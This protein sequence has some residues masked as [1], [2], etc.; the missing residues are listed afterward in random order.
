MATHVGQFHGAETAVDPFDGL[1]GLFKWILD[2]VQLVSAVFVSA[3]MLGAVLYY[4]WNPLAGA[5]SLGPIDGYWNC[6]L[7]VL[8]AFGVIMLVSDAL[9]GRLYNPWRVFKGSMHGR[10]M[11]KRVEFFDTAARPAAILLVAWLV[12]EFIR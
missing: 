12:A 10:L 1:D 3:L 9:Q 2:K 5:I 7:V 4:T 11:S 6:V 8:G